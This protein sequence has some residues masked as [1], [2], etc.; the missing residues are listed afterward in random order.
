MIRHSLLRLENVNPL[1]NVLEVLS[2]LVTRTFTI[3][4]ECAGVIHVILLELTN[5]ELTV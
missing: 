1:V 5:V 4:A 2:G 3:P